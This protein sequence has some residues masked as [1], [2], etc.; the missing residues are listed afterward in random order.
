MTVRV[1]LMVL[2][3][4]DPADFVRTAQRAEDQGFDFLAC[5][6]HAFFHAPTSNAFI[7][8]AAAAGA[9][10]R[11]RLMSALTLV[12]MYPAGLFAKMVAT[13]DR[14]CG[15]RLDL[16]VGIGGEYPAEFAACGIP[17]SERGPRADET[18]E[19][20]RRLF[21]GETV[22]FDGRFARLDGLELRPLPAQPGGPP[23]WVGGRR[24]A[25]TRRAGRFG[26]HW[27]PYMLSPEQLRTGL[28]DA[29]QAASDH[30]RNAT[31]VAGGAFLWAAVDDRPEAARSS[32]LSA[33]SSL[34]QQD[35]EQMADRYVPSGNPEQVASR[36]VEYVEAG[37]ESVLIS[38]ACTAE[39]RPAMVEQFASDV[40]PL[41]RD[42][43]VSP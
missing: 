16:G 38:P 24:S 23:V 13:L 28:A 11:I 9:T 17:M 36:L 4:E 10:T 34:Y 33:L 15:G 21:R 14:V 6:E 32:A 18:L 7:C 43:V 42:A 3:Q 12:P 30:G 22:D 25:A 27:L 35:F 41:L 40:L 19:I 37:A 26:T 1:G 8:L 29:R 39:E 2:P 20:C 31:A 5:G